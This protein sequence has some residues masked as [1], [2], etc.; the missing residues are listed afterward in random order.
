MNEIQTTF[1]GETD[2]RIWVPIFSNIGTS[3]SAAATSL[4]IGGP[5]AHPSVNSGIRVLASALESC[6]TLLGIVVFNLR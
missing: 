2:S 4:N 1:A 3:V 5:Q 6:L